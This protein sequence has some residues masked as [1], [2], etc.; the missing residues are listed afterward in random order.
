MAQGLALGETERQRRAALARVDRQQPRAEHLR[1]VRGVA[2]RQCDPAEQR[3]ARRQAREVEGRHAEADDVDGEDRRYATHHVGEHDADDPQREQDR[4]CRDPAQGDQQPDDQDRHL[5][6]QEHPHVEPEAAEDRTERRG[7]LVRREE[8]PTNA[9]P[10]GAGEDQCRDRA[11]HDDGRHG[12]DR[13]VTATAHS[14]GGSAVC[15]RG[16][17]RYGIV[18]SCGIHFWWSA[19]SVPLAVSV[20]IA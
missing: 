20:L 17:F 13:D 1:H 16:H 18:A 11:E 2:E 7:E 12:G 6:Q 9:R 14:P 3:R 5:G 8:Q 15:L 4:R 10:S 19:A